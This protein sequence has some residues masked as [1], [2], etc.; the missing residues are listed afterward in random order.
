MEITK[1]KILTYWRKLKSLKRAL[2][3]K[4]LFGFSQ[5]SHQSN[6]NN[7]KKK[8]NI[9]NGQIVGGV[10]RHFSPFLINIT[11]KIKL[12]KETATPQRNWDSEGLTAAGKTL[13]KKYPATL[14]RATAFDKS[15]QYRERSLY[16]EGANFIFIKPSLATANFYVNGNN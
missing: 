10:N 9:T 4:G 14:Y 8:E 3:G 16:W 6:G 11:A 12:V 15:S 13:G 5:N 7:Q 1:G 2:L